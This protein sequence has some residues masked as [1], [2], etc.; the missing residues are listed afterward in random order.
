MIQQSDT[1]RLLEEHLADLGVMVE[2]QVELETFKQ[3]ADS[4]TCNLVQADG[5]RESIEVSW[6]IGCDG[7]HSTVRHG[8]EWL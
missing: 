3:N 2:R 1:E 6:L 7:A 8:L 4:V 5:G